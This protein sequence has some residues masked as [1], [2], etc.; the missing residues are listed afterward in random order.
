MDTN[1]NYLF[2]IGENSSAYRLLGAHLAR[3]GEREGWRFSVYAPNAKAI[4]VVGDFNGWNESATPLHMVGTTGIWECFAQ[5]VWRGQRYKYRITGADGSNVLKADPFA[6]RA[7]MR[8][9]TASV[10]WGVPS[11]DW[12]DGDYMAR[13]TRENLFI[14]P[15]NIYEVHA[16]S[17]KS[18][19]DFEALAWELVDYCADMGYTHIELLPVSEFPLDD[20]WG[21]QCLGYYAVTARYGTPE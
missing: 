18:G 15:M 6:F 12:T 13:K 11:F 3:E 1:A 8:P 21:Y 5:N 14:K 4:S 9:G 17:W 16:G 20:S 19:R 2:N 10:I 7:E